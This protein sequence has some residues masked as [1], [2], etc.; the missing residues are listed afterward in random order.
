[1]SIFTKIRIAIGRSLA[2]REQQ[3]GLRTRSQWRRSDWKINLVDLVLNGILVVVWRY[4]N[5]LS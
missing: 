3:R 5:A 1:M 4:L 2:L